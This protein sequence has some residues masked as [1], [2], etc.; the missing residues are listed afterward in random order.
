MVM[1]VS[2]TRIVVIAAVM[3]LVAIAFETWRVLQI[4]SWNRLIENGQ[5][6]LAQDRSPR[7]VRFAG[8][9]WLAKQG[10]FVSALTRYRQLAGDKHGPTHNA[11]LLNEGNLLLREALRVRAVEDVERAGPLLE[12][13]KE[14][15]R[16]LLRADP[17]DWDAKYNLELALRF[18]PEPDEDASETLP[19]PIGASRQAPT[20]GES[21][22]L[23]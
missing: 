10:E 21:L 12:M 8:A 5:A 6:V 15:Y 9:Y 20:R 11:A 7:D 1:R 22:G 13:A 23:P 16:E 14:S 3:C 19:P 17:E 2:H 4:R 18:A